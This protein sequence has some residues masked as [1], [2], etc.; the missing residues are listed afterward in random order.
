MKN[1]Y[2][3]EELFRFVPAAKAVAALAVPAVTSQIITVIYNMADT[4]YIGQLGDPDQVAAATVAM[5]LFMIM[6]ALANLF[7]IGGSSLVSRSLGMNDREKAEHCSSF[8]FWT[9][10]VFAFVYGL[11]VLALK[12]RLLPVLGANED[13]WAFASDYLFWTVTVGAVPTVLNPMLAHLVRAEGHAGEASVGVAFGGILNIILD[14]VFI[15][16]LGMDITGAAVATLV[17][18]TAAVIYYLL[19][20]YRIRSSTAISLSL[21]NYSVKDRIPAE[22]ISVGLPSCLISVMAGIS[23]TVLNHTIAG[24]SNKAVAGMGI[25]KRIDLLAFAIAQG[26]TQGSL[27]LIGYNY[28]SGDSKRL[29]EIA[30]KLFIIC[31]SVSLAGFALLYLGAGTVT[32]LFI[33]DSATVDYGRGFLRIICTSCP[34]TSLTFFA[35][36]IFQA[37]GKKTP[38]IFLSLIR[39]G[40][41]DVAL[42]F[43]F[44]RAFGIGGV[45][46]ATPVAEYVSFAVSTALVVPYLKKLCKMCEQ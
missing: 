30:K 12:K 18:N 22:V 8:C 19:F 3:E 39:K 14:P 5:P 2:S 9:V 1:R 7:G 27:P 24:Y 44:D 28:S 45:A 13:T 34:A 4:Y 6:T 10:C 41:I 11:S 29:K 38:P 31:L 40:T 32:G 25:A 36:V 20:L 15:F 16:V 37:T 42:M 33:D 26:M 17:S 21:S 46:W 35:L 23:N 43:I